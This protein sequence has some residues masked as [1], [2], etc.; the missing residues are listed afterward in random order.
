MAIGVLIT[1]VTIAYILAF[2][3][4]YACFHFKSI[5]P[6]LI[7]QKRYPKLVLIEAYVVI[8]YLFICVPFWENGNYDVTHFGLSMNAFSIFK[9]ITSNCLVIPVIHFIPIIE[10]TRLWLIS[11]DLHYLQRSINEQWKTQI[12]HSFAQKDWYL[13]N[14]NTFGNLKYVMTKTLIYYS[15]V[16]VFLTTMNLIDHFSYAGNFA[17]IL[18]GVFFLIDIIFVFYI[19]F[20]CRKYAALNDNLLFYYEFKA[21]TI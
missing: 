21:T 17:G 9:A 1:I 15:C 16:A 13:K 7:V 8:F 3:Q 10:I 20:K 19:Y 12:D 2:L 6:L 4:I 14:R 5:Q 18:N 11:Y